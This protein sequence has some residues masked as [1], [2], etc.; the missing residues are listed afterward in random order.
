[1]PCGKPHGLGNLEPTNMNLVLVAKLVTVKLIEEIEKEVEH[2]EMVF[3][4]LGIIG[5]FRG[6]WPSLGDLHKLILVHWEPIVERCV[7]IYPHARGYFIVVFQSVENKNKVLGG[8]HWY[9]WE[10]SHPLMLKPWHLNF[11]PESESFERTLV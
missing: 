4:G 7:Q 5:H 1:M 6:L 8:G 2:N 11:N 3:V 9:C 10:D